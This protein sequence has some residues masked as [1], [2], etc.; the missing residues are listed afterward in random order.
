MDADDISLED[1]LQTQMDYLNQNSN[2]DAVGVQYS[3]FCSSGNQAAAFTSCFSL[4]DIEIKINFIFGYDFLFGGS[5]MRMK[6]IKQHNLFFDNNYKFSTGEDHQYIID[7][8]SFMKFA[9]ID[10][11]L[12]IV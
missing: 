10:K 5:L 4:S 7:C 3:T 9:N 11:V 8:F 12:F 2:I 6:K 1:R